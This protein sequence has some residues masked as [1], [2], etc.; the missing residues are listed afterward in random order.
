LSA[1]GV[2]SDVRQVRTR[3]IGMA[4]Q[5]SADRR[6]APAKLRSD[7][8]DRQTKPVQ[9]RDLEPLAQH[10][11]SGRASLRDRR[12]FGWDAIARL[13]PQPNSRSS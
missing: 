2:V 7:P 9:V 4:A 13:P 10:Q 8:T 3:R 5:L 11:V 6:W 12:C 1:R